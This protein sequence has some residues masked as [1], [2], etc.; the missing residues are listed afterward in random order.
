MAHYIGVD[1]VEIGGKDRLLRFKNM[2]L[3]VCPK[4]YAIADVDYIWEGA[5]NELRADVDLSQL[6]QQCWN[7]AEQ[8]LARD[9][10]MNDLNGEKK[11]EK[12]KELLKKCC[13]T[14]ESC[15]KRTAVCGKLEALGTLVLS[16]GSIEAYVGLGKESKGKYLSAAREIESGERNL[17]FEDEL[18]GIYS[19][20]IR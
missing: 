2:L 8:E 4:V 14:N 18:R 10:S 3:N 17:N 19:K 1:I 12:L 9:P 15:D 20:I 13:F 7:K 5:G 16:R 6:V 11:A